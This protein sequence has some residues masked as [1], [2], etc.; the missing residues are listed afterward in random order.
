MAAPRPTVFLS[1]R[2]HVSTCIARAVFQDLRQHGYDV[3]MDVESME[4][5]P[6]ET[7]LLAQIAARTHFLGLL[8][9]GTLVECQEP[10]DWLRREMEYAMALGRTVIP[11]LVNDFRFDDHARAS[12][13]GSGHDLPRFAGL[14][15]R[16]DALDTAMERL[17]TRFLTRPAQGSITPTPRQ[18]I[19][20]VQQKIAEIA[21]Q[22]APTPQELAA[23]DAFTRGYAL[24]EQSDEASTYYTEALRINTYYAIA[25]NHRG[26]ARRAQGDQAGAIA[27][28]EHFLALGGGKRDG[29][30]EEV[31]QRIRA[32]RAQLDEARH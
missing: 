28:Y 6:C 9:H 26:I 13:P 4:S 7:L 1:Y 25:Y 21:S 20:L 27:D 17:R 31:A 30:Q 14:E 29:D 2:R 15:L 8:T 5:G 32:L 10:D 12:L 11:L 18:D 24:Q 3:F 16:H 19:P 22:P 23:E